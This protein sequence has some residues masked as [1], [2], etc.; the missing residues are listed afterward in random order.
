VK[1]KLQKVMNKTVRL[2]PNSAVDSRK[3]GHINR[4]L[5]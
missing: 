4:N 5:H 2:E 1:K 3:Q